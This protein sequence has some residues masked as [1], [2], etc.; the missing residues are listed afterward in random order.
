MLACGD[1][2]CFSTVTNISLNFNK[3]AGLLSS[4]SPEQLYHNSTQSGLANMSRMSSVE[5]LCPQATEELSVTLNYAGRILVPGRCRPL[6]E[7][8]WAP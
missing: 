1:T 6:L 5:A 2:D 7:I 4:M 8:G 3:Q